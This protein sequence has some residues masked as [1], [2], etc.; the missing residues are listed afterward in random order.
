MRIEN[1]RIKNFRKL[2]DCPICLTNKETI[3]VGAN[4]SG[5]TSAMS[6]LRFFLSDRKIEPTDFSLDVWEHI[7][8]IGDTWLDRES[9][10]NE[11]IDSWKK[12][13]PQLDITINGFV[14][15]DLPKIKHLLP[16]LTWKNSPIKIRLNFIPNELEKLKEDFVRHMQML[17][18][19]DKEGGLSIAKN[20]REFLAQKNMLTKYFAKQAYLVGEEDNEKSLDGDPLKGIFKV[21]IIE[22]GRGFSDFDDKK[23][24][25]DLSQGL[26]K[27]YEEHL[28]PKTE[29]TEDD[30]EILRKLKG[31]EQSLSD[32]L[33]HQFKGHFDE[34]ST[35]GYPSVHGD[36]KMSLSSVIDSPQTL[37]GQTTVHFNLQG[38]TDDQFNLPEKLNGLGYRNL[39]F[40]FFQLLAFRDEWRR[41]GKK[42]NSDDSGIEPIHLVLIEEPEAHLHAQ[43][44]QVFIK[45]A[46]SFLGAFEGF[47]TQLLIST[48]SSYI[49]H[50]VGFESLCYFNRQNS[51]DKNA[52]PYSETVELATVFS[53]NDEREKT[54]KFVSRYLRVMHCDLLFADAV[55]MVEGT[56]ERMLLPHF[57]RNKFE[58]VLNSRYLSILEVGGAHAHRF[59]PLLEQLG[60]PVLIIADLDSK[61]DSK[62]IPPKRGD[63]QL[64]GCQA[65]EKWFG[66]DDMSLETVLDLKPEQK[67]KNDVCI[68]YQV[69]IDVKF[70]DSSQKAIPYTFEDAIALSNIGLI[71]NQTGLTG[72]LNKMQEAMKAKNLEACCE[73][74]FKALEKDKAQMALDI[75]YDLDIEELTVPNYIE[76]G[77]KWLESRLVINSSDKGG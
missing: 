72:M 13:C 57:I 17:T 42:K 10:E 34:L 28:D 4:N 68:A 30:K 23:P 47:T 48:H 7:N 63:N 77:L 56:A 74:M 43:V 21:S 53:E 76:E 29:P 31:L 62:K 59:K 5:K 11:E 19:E 51:D 33:S 32:T 6:A 14:D 60:I 45:K 64:S 39:I 27:Y 1:I 16:N 26:G 38:G 36:P 49:A 41:E 66:Q 70:G 35:L 75:M 2:K 3:F 67:R 8:E 50:E 24:S 25:R 44:Q 18:D 46:Y 73:K 9:A 22:A 55:I 15:A 58:K 65:L 20:M 54:Q 52:I 12:H 61:K 37:K 69:G 71:Q 40:M